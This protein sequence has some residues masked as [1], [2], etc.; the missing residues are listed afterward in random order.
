MVLL[1]HEVWKTV[2]E[3]VAC[4]LHDL[5]HPLRLP[6]LLQTTLQRHRELV[7][8]ALARGSPFLPAT[9]GSLSQSMMNMRGQMQSILVLLHGLVAT[10]ASIVCTSSGRLR[11]K[12]ATSLTVVF[13][14][15]SRP[16][17]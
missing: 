17:S 13:H 6:A 4:L 10:A 3:W 14:G 2:L 8:H 9:A 1:Q 7:L 11:S 16:P 12:M 5:S 15:S